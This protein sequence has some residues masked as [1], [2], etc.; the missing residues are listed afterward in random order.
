MKKLPYSEGGKSAAICTRCNEIVSTTFA[1]RD[2]DFGDGTKDV[3]N[4]LAAVCDLCLDVVGIPAQ[5]AP[6]F[7]MSKTDASEP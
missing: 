6:G 7:N 2:V 1:M 4:V 5:S 3:R